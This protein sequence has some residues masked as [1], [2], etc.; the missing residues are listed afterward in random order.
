M[1]DMG[2]RAPTDPATDRF[3]AVSGLLGEP[4]RRSSSAKPMTKSRTIVETVCRS[5]DAPSVF[6][7]VNRKKLPAASDACCYEWPMRWVPPIARAYSRALTT[8]ARPASLPPCGQPLPHT[9]PHLFPVDFRKGTDPSV[10]GQVAMEHLTPGIPA[11]EYEQRRKMLMDR[12]PEKSAVV[13]MGGRTKYMSRNIFYK[14]RQESNFWV[15]S[16][17]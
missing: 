13:L 15:R 3:S 4:V 7:H 14:F 1:P 8:A 10:G 11:T 16:V 12:L 9:H 2:T 17:C 5:V 6:G